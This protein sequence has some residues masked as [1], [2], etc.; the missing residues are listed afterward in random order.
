[1]AEP[2]QEQIRNLNRTSRLVLLVALAASGLLLLGYGYSSYGEYVAQQRKLAE[3]SVAGTSR[4]ISEALLALAR[5]T[6]LFVAGERA[7]VEAALARQDDDSFSKVLLDNVTRAYPNAVSLSLVNMQGKVLVEA[8]PGLLDSTSVDML[9][10]RVHQLDEGLPFDPFMLAADRIDVMM[11]FKPTQGERIMVVLSFDLNIV[12]RMLAN[13]QVYRHW[14]LLL[15]ASGAETSVIAGASNNPLTRE[16]LRVVG[17][18]TDTVV[19]RAPVIGTEWQL[20]GMP[21]PELLPAYA[22][23]LALKMATVWLLLGGVFGI[24]LFLFD[25][26]N[27]RVV[28][29]NHAL[30]EENSNLQYLGLH[31]P[32]TGLANRTLLEERVRQAQLASERSGESF[33][34]MIID[35]D[36][37]KSVNDTLGHPVGDRLL[38]QIGRRLS[39]LLR[40]TD[41]IARFG[42]DEFA[43][44]ARIESR[45]QVGLIAAKVLD[46]FAEPFDLDGSPIQVDASIGV[47]ICP[48]HGTDSNTLMELADIA[49]YRAKKAGSRFSV[50]DDHYEPDRLDRMG[51]IGR[52]RDAINN[53]E[54]L[55]YH[56]PKVNALDGTLHGIE[57][58]VRWHH[59]QH[60]LLSP[61]TFLPLA[62]QTGA[63]VPLTLRV[64]QMAFDT[65]VRLQSRGF[66]VRVAVNLAARTFD[67]SNFPRVV[68]DLLEEWHVS[69]RSLQFE[70]TEGGLLSDVNKAL[71]ILHE[72]ND[73]GIRL[74]I[75]DFGVG[76]SSLTYL[77]NLPVHEL[78]ID[79][80]FVMGM[81]DDNSDAAIVR[82]TIE[83]AHNL[84]L[85][86]V[87]EGVEN[88][89]TLQLLRA[90]G[91]DVIQGEFIGS[92]M[93]EASLLK[94]LTNRQKLG[95]SGKLPD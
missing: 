73:I 72:L 93:D 35:L 30:M 10:A 95:T 33:A 55:L 32:L 4:K 49:M 85:E 69:P 68:A 91:C 94:W 87:C 71:H 26:L 16:Y 65:H 22:R 38:G 44:L 19:V 21:D 23:R 77:K 66:S 90:Y 88:N 34:V 74:S 14:L 20:L 59:P 42:G 17:S 86:V 11:R 18:E 82:S 27:Q 37:F 41:T 80:S 48:Q 64:L 92:A 39:G 57:S 58:L 53:D 63:I 51:L 84:G 9:R 56:Q 45:E 62:E 43:V 40:D 70:I 76:Y 50:Y 52:V 89:E 13:S 28:Q 12:T 78:K 25:R 8:Q 5:S 1:M 29:R 31:D 75:D 79:K 67:D 3:V 15:D 61:D 60:G 54:L 6:R 36:R 7:V 24:T 83:L 81:K 2:V 46:Q 47:S